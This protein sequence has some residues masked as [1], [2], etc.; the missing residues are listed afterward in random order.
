MST[1]YTGIILVVLGTLFLLVNCG[2]KNP[3]D[4]WL[5]GDSITATKPMDEYP[6]TGWG[7][8]LPR[9]FTNQV[10][11]HNHAKNGRS[12]KSFI[13]EGRWET[14]RDSLDNGDWVFIQ[15]GHN[16]QKAYDT[17]RYAP[18]QTTFRDNLTRFVREARDNGANPVL[19]TPVVRRKFNEA[20][21]LQATHGE[22]PE[23]VRE[24]ADELD[25]YF[26]DMHRKSW[27]LVSREGPAGSKALFLLLE[28][29]EYDTWPE[30]L[31]DNT[32]LSEDGATKICSLM[33]QG[34]EGKNMELERYLAR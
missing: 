2:R 3:V 26:I 1:R 25:T 16:D 9:F 20:G 32:H 31:T 4:I 27:E 24:T 17:T 28:P 7:Q 21:G 30:G 15:F 22:Y 19:M 14:V 11:I 34:I 12:T 6:R 13:N 10:R 33:V 8:V 5:V 23:V 18:P 29:G